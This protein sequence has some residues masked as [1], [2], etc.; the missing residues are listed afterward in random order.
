MGG[1]L[2]RTPEPSR[3]RGPPTKSRINPEAFGVQ[4]IH[5]DVTAH[6]QSVVLHYD[7]D[8]FLRIEMG[9]DGSG[10]GVRQPRPFLNREHPRGQT[11]SSTSARL[12]FICPAVL[13]A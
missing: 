1:A 8:R 4:H 3:D 2:H 11:A 7:H 12:Y 9:P 10:F 5:Q 6:D 13:L